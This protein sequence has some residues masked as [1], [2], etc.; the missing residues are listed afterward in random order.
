MEPSIEEQR[1]MDAR[2]WE[3]GKTGLGYMVSVKLEEWQ[4]IKT[5]L[6]ALATSLDKGHPIVPGTGAHHALRTVLNNMRG[7]K[8]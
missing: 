6:A 7:E 1:R 2:N 4:Q 5:V 8:P 3:E